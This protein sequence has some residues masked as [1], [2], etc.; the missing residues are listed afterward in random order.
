MGLT[1]YYRKFIRSYDSICR[2]LTLLLEKCPYVC[3]ED[4]Q[5]AFISLKESLTNAP[6]LGI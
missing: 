2:P 5:S 6:V 4:A 3:N 1:G